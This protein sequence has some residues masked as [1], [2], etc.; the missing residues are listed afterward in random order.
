MQKQSMLWTILQEAAA[1][2]S[3]L[4]FVAMIMVWAHFITLF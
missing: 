4:L 3:L 1:L 2:L